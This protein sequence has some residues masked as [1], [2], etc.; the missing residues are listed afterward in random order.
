MEEIKC[1]ISLDELIKFKN[2]IDIFLRKHKKYLYSF[3]ND[4]GTFFHQVQDLTKLNLTSTITCLNSSIAAKFVEDT[5]IENLFEILLNAKWISADLEENNCYTSSLMLYGLKNLKDDID[6]NESKYEKILNNLNKIRENIETYGGLKVED[7]DENAFLTFWGFISYE[8]FYGLKQT[9]TD[10]KKGLECLAKE[11]YYQLSNFY[12]NDLYNKDIYQLG[13]ALITLLRYEYEIST[14]IINKAFSIFF[15]DQRENGSWDRYNPLFHYPEKGNAYCF[16]FEL[17][18]NFFFLPKKFHVKFEEYIK[19]FEKARSWIN[20]HEKIKRTEN[21]VSGWSSYHHP[22]WKEPESWTTACIFD[23]LRNYNSILKNLIRKKILS[24]LKA[25]K[26]FKKNYW[27]EEL[28]DVLVEVK[29]EKLFLKKIILDNVINPIKNGKR[30]KAIGILFYGPP[31]TGKTLYA[32]SIAQELKMHLI[33][34]NPSHFLVEG[35]G[36]LVRKATEIVDKLKYLENVVVLFDEM[37]ELIRSRAG[38]AEYETRLF[39]TS[40]LPMF[41]D[42]HDKENFVYICNTNKFKNIDKASIRPG[43]FDLSIFIG[44]PYKEESLKMIEEYIR[45]L[46]LNDDEKSFYCSIFELK[47]KE[48]L[49]NLFYHDIQDLLL[50]TKNLILDGLSEKEFTE[51]LNK[52]IQNYS[53]HAKAEFKEY[54][55]GKNDSKIHFTP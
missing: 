20:T 11:L 23:F 17:L 44:P 16:P 54:E 45:K 46:D 8:S 24:S 21:N 55:Y 31:G 15:S 25:Q 42:L 39:T 29:S 3:R 5:E 26:E 9:K 7:Y 28:I 51:E 37:E 41:S 30:K 47:F 53:K 32:K 1:D 13:Y 52:I 2:E 19:N 6:I 33:I 10:L 18:K 36:G 4:D 50:D 43:R 12:A 40:M 49:S 22:N 35:F 14:P 34:L 48:E 38:N 27:N